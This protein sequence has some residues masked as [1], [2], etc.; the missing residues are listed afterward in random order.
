MRAEKILSELY[1]TLKAAGAEEI[2]LSKKEETGL[3]SDV[4]VMLLDSFGGTTNT[5]QCEFYFLPK[6]TLG[7][8]MFFCRI[9]LT[10]EVVPENIPGLCAEIAVLN[11]EVPLGAFSF[12]V[13]ENALIYQVNLPLSEGLTTTEI[14]EEADGCIASAISVSGRYAGTLVPLAVT[15]RR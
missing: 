8:D 5:A 13:N 3:P 7:T 11:L 6:E 12:E 1:K 2:T 15:W 9:T 4:I 10:E 14:Q